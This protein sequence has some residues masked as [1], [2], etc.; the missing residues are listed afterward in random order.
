VTFLAA[1][2]GWQT[3]FAITG[4]ASLVTAVLCIM[5]L[6]PGVR[7][8]TISPGSWAALMHNRA[9][10]LLLALTVT[11]TTAQLTVLTYL[12]PLLARLAGAGSETIAA[13]FSLFG[14]ASFAG[15]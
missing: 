9:V 15:T 10:L 14:V 13:F 2:A 1:H 11:S 3:A 6:P 12:R 5:A 8:S 4:A 7:G